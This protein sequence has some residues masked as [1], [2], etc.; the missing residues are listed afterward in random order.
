MGAFSLITDSTARVPRVVVVGLASC[1][2]CQLQITN[3]EAHLT[4]ILGQIDLRYW[5]LVTSEDMVG[6][7]DVAIIEG[8]GTT[9][10]SE[11]TCRFLRE[12]AAYVMAIGA[13]ACTGGVT[14]M[15]SNGLEDRAAYAAVLMPDLAVT[16]LPHTAFPVAFEVQL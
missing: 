8:A 7:F 12:H 3:A 4:D 10:E 15:A 6:D 5:Q 11:A 1:F 2:G 13:C 14:G 16:A 9:S